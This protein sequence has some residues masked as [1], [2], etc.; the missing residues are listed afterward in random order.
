[1]ESLDIKA[2]FSLK[3]HNAGFFLSRGRDMHPHRTIDSYELTFV[4]RGVLG[5]YEEDKKFEIKAGESLLLFPGRK[6][7][8]T[9]KYSRELC[10]YWIHFSL[11]GRTDK[12][13][14]ISIPQHIPVKRT[15]R[16][17]E[18]YR[19]FLDDQEH[20]YNNTPGLI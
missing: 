17:A 9:T 16:L 7:G 8:G 14:T 20:G 4:D 19:Y 13:Q 15:E 12:G 3:A 11:S 10:Y 1:M 2:S 18:L 5:M 6:H